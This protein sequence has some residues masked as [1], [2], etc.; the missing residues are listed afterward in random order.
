MKIL[1]NDLT[2]NARYFKIENTRYSIVGIILDLGKPD[3]VV[4]LE[5]GVKKKLTR[6]ELKELI[7]KYNACAY[8][9]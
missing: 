2:L 5:T 8:K 4:N 3:I 7:T 1:N 6:L 9:K